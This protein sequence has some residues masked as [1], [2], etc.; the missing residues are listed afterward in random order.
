M[1]MPVPDLGQPRPRPMQL[2]KV[3]TTTDDDEATKLL[4]TSGWIMLNSFPNQA[5]G[6]DEGPVVYLFGLTAN[7]NDN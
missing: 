3:K 1:T 6:V 7:P 5:R 4:N 2:R